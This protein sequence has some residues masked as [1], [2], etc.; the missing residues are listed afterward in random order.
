MSSKKGARRFWTPALRQAVARLDVARQA[1]EAALTQEH[2]A[3]FRRFASRHA[4][5]NRAVRC[6]GELDCLLSLAVACAAIP[7][8]TRPKLVARGPQTGNRPLLRVRGGFHLLA[9]ASSPGGSFVANDVALGGERDGSCGTD[10]QGGPEPVVALVTGP[11]MGGKSTLLRQTALL[12]LMAQL[13]CLVPA[14][15]AELTPAD[16]IYTRVGA[17]DRI[18]AGQST[19]KVELE[20]TSAI[21]HGATADSLVILD[22]LGAPPLPPS[23]PSPSPNSCAPRLP[24]LPAAAAACLS[25][26]PPRPSAAARSRRRP[27]DG[28][29]RRDGDR[30]RR[31]QPP[32]AAYGLPHAL[33]HALPPS[34]GA[35]RGGA[36]RRERPPHG[37]RR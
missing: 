9:A 33:R 8:L 21:L 28:D 17:A 23:P 2:R 31:A 37:L 10:S 29:L 13:G 3:L 26:L 35:A 19:F 34:C 11:N 25:R 36:R 15:H 5:W 20:E 7:G 16:A 32:D 22:E 18:L 1:K 24:C 4:L 12:T 6:V 30:A 14:A 27:R